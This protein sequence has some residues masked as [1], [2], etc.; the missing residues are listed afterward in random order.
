MH[1]NSII[2]GFMRVGGVWY[3][4]NGER[5][6]SLSSHRV[7]SRGIKYFLINLV[8]QRIEQLSLW[9]MRIAGAEFMSVDGSINYTGLLANNRVK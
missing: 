9:E 4:A 8:Q 6:T 1:M 7:A 3:F 5:Q 2:V